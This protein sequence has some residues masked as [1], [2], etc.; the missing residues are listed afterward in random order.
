MPKAPR[1]TEEVVFE[2]QIVSRAS[3]KREVER[4]GREDRR[5]SFGGKHKSIRKMKPPTACL[6]CQAV[7]SGSEK[8]NSGQMHFIPPPSLHGPQEFSCPASS[9]TLLSNHSIRSCQRTSRVHR[10]PTLRLDI[11]G[12]GPSSGDGMF[13]SCHV[14]IPNLAH[15]S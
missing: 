12:F 11:V 2:E 6:D 13:V 14:V 5:Q 10:F 15:P 1:R 3:Q 9:P 8:R 4:T 7:Q